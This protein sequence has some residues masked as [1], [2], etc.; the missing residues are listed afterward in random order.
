MRGWNRH[1]KFVSPME[2]SVA[3]PCW[4]RHTLL[5]SPC[6][7]GS[8][9]PF[10]Y[11]HAL[12]IFPCRAGIAIPGWYRHARLVSPCPAGDAMYVSPCRI[13]FGILGSFLLALLFLVLVDSWGILAQ[14]P[15][16]NFNYKL[17]WPSRVKKKMEGGKRKGRGEG[18][19]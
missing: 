16:M 10:S 8:A 4:Y 5:I 1:D 7:A 12:L 15:A 17:F 3:I 6:T 11:L 14:K 19:S 2:A 18:P 9:T 13:G